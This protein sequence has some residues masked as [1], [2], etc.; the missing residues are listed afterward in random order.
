MAFTYG[1]WSQDLVLVVFD[2][3]FPL[4]NGN[5]SDQ[6][7]VGWLKTLFILLLW[8]SMYWCAVDQCWVQAWGGGGWEGWK[9]VED[10]VFASY[11]YIIRLHVEIFWSESDA[12]MVRNEISTDFISSCI[13][14]SDTSR[15][16]LWDCL[17]H[18]S[19]VLL[20]WK[21]ARCEAASN[22]TYKK[23]CR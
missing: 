22:L 11:M 21:L 8:Y 20:I 23:K 5:S 6:H 7:V 15:G 12:E 14:S 1:R 19:Q 9:R 16:R 4:F 17:N 10:D 13:T 2:S 3:D 18:Y